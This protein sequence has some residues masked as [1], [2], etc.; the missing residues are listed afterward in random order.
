MSIA[1]QISRLT[2]LR[3]NIRTKLINLGIISDSSA[4]LEDCYNAING[5]TAKS[6]ATITPTTTAQTISAGQYLTGAQTIAGDANLLAQNV[7]K[8]VPIFG[9]TGT[10]DGP[11]RISQQPEVGI[12]DE[13]STEATHVF[14]IAVSGG[15]GTY[16]Y[17]WQ[18]L[19]SAD[20][21]W[22]NA[23]S[24]SDHYSVITN[25]NRSKY[26]YRCIVSDGT[27]TLTSNEVFFI[28][29]KEAEV[30]NASA[31]DR[32]ITFGYRLTGTQTIKAVT[33]NNIS[34]G[35]I[36]SGVMV[37][38]GDA[39]DDDRIA[40]VTG[41]FTS[42]STV[43]SGQTAAT[44]GQIISG[45]SAWVNGAEVLGTAPDATNALLYSEQ[46]LTESQIAQVFENLGLGS[47]AT[48]GYTTIT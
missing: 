2:T 44:A 30:F 10:Y 20:G 46:T 25:N 7:K 48:L 27:T 29:D 14:N 1:T 17:Q 15:S 19:P 43:S 22:T 47:A 39:N 6:A 34:A 23:S 45:Y 11:F 9:V 8:N 42:S 26:R 28:C 24:T 41:T 40:G 32:T 16:T 31:S 33:T 3:N 37:K 21:S 12:T 5:I 4:D 13:L 38:V 18:Y 35:N 36:K